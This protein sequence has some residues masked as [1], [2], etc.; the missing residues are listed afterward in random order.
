MCTN[1]SPV[2]L[3]VAGT[4]ERGRRKTKKR[5]ETTVP[6]MTPSHVLPSCVP[7]QTNLIPF[8]SLHKLQECVTVIAHRPKHI[9]NTKMCAYQ[10]SKEY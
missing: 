3:E 6:H 8:R 2:R 10:Y 5:T 9:I 7:R 4:E 1:H